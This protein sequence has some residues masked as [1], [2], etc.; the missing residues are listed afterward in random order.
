[1]NINAGLKG[2]TVFISV[3]TGAI[4]DAPWVLGFPLDQLR[5]VIVKLVHLED[6]QKEAPNEG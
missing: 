5:E 3:S 6:Q 4:C 2:S 1:M